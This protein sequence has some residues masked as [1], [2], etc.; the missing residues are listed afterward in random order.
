MLCASISCAIPMRYI[1]VATSDQVTCALQLL[2]I[3]PR[4]D[5]H[6]DDLAPLGVSEEMVSLLNVRARPIRQKSLSVLTL[7]CNPPFSVQQYNWLTSTL[8][9]DKIGKALKLFDYILEKAT[10]FSNP[11]IHEVC[12]SAI[13]IIDVR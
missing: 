13:T 8:N 12:P 1:A 7:Y 10:I 6:P 9:R 11:V 5:L 3:I 2:C 4:E